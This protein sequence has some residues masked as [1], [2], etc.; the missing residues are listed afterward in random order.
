MIL[1]NNRNT[2][3]FR[4]HVVTAQKRVFYHF[5]HMDWRPK[6]VDGDD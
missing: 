2:S 5:S 3:Y 4:N 6:V 1:Y